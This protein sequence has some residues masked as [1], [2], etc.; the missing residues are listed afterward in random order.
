MTSKICFKCGVDKPLTDYY[1][2]KRMGDGHLNKCKECTKKDTKER[3]DILLNNPEWVEQEQA[4]HREKYYRLGYKE[5][6]K[7]SA[8]DKKKVMSAHWD[9]YPE[10]KAARSHVPNIK[11]ANGHLHH[12]SYNEIHFKDVIDISTK[13]HYKAH[14]FIIYD[15]E[16]KMYR[17]IDN[18]ELL[19]T[20]EKHIEWIEF[21]IITKPD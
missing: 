18:N 15:Q 5:K 4:R 10:K 12:W 21:C 19:D 1:P 7:P 14:R 2:H 16:R 8:D 17:R 9:K 6:H 20:R 3:A 11:S 13:N